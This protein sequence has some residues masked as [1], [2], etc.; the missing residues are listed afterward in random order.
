[1]DAKHRWC[2]TGTPVTNVRPLCKLCTLLFTVSNA[3]LSGRVSQIFSASQDSFVSCTTQGKVCLAEAFA[4]FEPWND[5]KY[6]DA[7]IGRVQKRRVELAGAYPPLATMRACFLTLCQVGAPK[8]FS[9]VHYFVVRRPPKWFVLNM[10][11]SKLN[12]PVLLSR[13]GLLLLNSLRNTWS[14]S[15]LSSVIPNAR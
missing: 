10:Q 13:K 1:M 6:F 2:L 11:V 3:P 15:K 8:L 5:W 4:G 14:S 7:Q 9:S 12:L